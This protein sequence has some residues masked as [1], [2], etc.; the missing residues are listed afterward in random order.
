MIDYVSE[1][2]TNLLGE[3][4]DGGNKAEAGLSNACKL[5]YV[6]FSNRDELY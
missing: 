4:A 5:V 2:L 1:N 6:H 3:K